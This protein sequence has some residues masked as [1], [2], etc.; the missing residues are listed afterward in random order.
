MHFTA[1]G[2]LDVSPML[3]RHLGQRASLGVVQLVHLSP[4]QRRGLLDGLISREGVRAQPACD[5][6]VPIKPDRFPSV[7]EPYLEASAVIVYAA[8]RDDANEVALGHG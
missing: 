6:I 7:C 5:K 3:R 8:V 1:N 4:R 2:G